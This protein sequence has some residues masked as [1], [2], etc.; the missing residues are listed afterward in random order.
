MALQKILLSS[1]QNT[2][3]LDNILKNQTTNNLA[4]SVNQESKN[5]NSVSFVD[6]EA[7]YPKLIDSIDSTS[8]GNCGKSL[9]I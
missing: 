7:I 6:S 9:M 5:E 2:N 4:N 8:D 3:T 1:V